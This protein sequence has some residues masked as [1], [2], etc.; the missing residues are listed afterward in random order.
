[1]I[2]LMLVK[3]DL[4]RYV[5][6]GR[7]MRIMGRGL[8]DHHAILCKVRLVWHGLRGKKFWMGLGGLKMKN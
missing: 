4:L 3:K 1:M 8:S 7:A 5:Q 6:D 2:D